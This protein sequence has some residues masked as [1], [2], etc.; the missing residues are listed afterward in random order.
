MALLYG[1]VGAQVLVGI[2]DS[3]VGGQN[4]LRELRRLRDK[5]DIIYLADYKNAPYGTK[6]KEEIL[7]IVSENIKRLI[8][9]GCERVLVACCTASAM[10]G[11][12]PVELRPHASGVIEPTLE[13]IKRSG[14]RRIA[15]IATDRT[16]SEG[17][18]SI[19]KR[20]VV[21]IRAQR[22][23]GIVERGEWDS[24]YINELIEKIRE[25]SATALILGCTH[26]SHLFDRFSAAL[27]MMEI[28]SPA[29]IGAAHFSKEINNF[30]EGRTEYIQ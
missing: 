29:T 17:A 14:H 9:L 10:L 2:F 22:L 30:G 20:E 24:P 27:S 1:R 6:T 25:T 26:F 11:C 3:G 4:S 8:S 5:V 19:P 23:V 7:P 28:F 21:A 12:L 16:V 13:K 18:F 15:L